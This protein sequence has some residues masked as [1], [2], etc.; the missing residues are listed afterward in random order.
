[1]SFTATW[2][3]ERKQE[4]RRFWDAVLPGG[5]SNMLSSFLFIF[6]KKKKPKPKPQPPNPTLLLV[7][8]PP[9]T[10]CLN[11][12]ILSY[13]ASS[14]NKLFSHPLKL[15]PLISELFLGSCGLF[16][17]LQIPDS[18]YFSPPS[19]I[20]SPR[21]PV[22]ASLLGLLIQTQP[23]P[24]TPHPS[25]IALLSVSR[26][27][28][29]LLQQY[30]LSKSHSLPPPGPSFS[31]PHSL[32]RYTADLCSSVLLETVGGSKARAETAF[33]STCVQSWDSFQ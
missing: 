30:L 33:L 19:Q 24:S 1:M 15:E 16:L 3:L 2:W 8:S 26:L 6:Q 27:S 32:C 9:L 7:P 28:W 17:Y 22:S 21:F 20:S 29:L 23:W 31:A 18:S 11:P 14:P 4:T 10:P 25:S 13:Q 12:T 5:V